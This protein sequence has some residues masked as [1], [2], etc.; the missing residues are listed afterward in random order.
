M[1]ER[2]LHFLIPLPKFG[3]GG[4]AG[5]EITDE[6]VASAG[7]KDVPCSTFMYA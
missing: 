1:V 6:H 4:T 3:S 7:F 5:A 2:G